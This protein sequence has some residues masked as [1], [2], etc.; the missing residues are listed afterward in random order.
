MDYYKKIFEILYNDKDTI[1]GDRQDTKY[2][3]FEKLE[4]HVTF[5]FADDNNKKTDLFYAIL[6]ELQDGKIVLGEMR[7]SYKKQIINPSA[8]FD[9]INAPIRVFYNNGQYI[10]LEDMAED[11]EFEDI[12]EKYSKDKDIKKVLDRLS[13][14]TRSIYH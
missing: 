7:V 2:I 9:Y 14:I 6:V 8:P 5:L 10:S 4:E 12:Y 11:T 3:A 1:K 13:N